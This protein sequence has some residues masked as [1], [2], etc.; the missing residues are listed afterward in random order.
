MGL[1]RHECAGQG[2]ILPVVMK[3]SPVKG[4]QCKEGSE[5]L[6]YSELLLAFLWPFW[7]S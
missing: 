6:R 3:C 2:H 7:P 5:E 4:A 1:E